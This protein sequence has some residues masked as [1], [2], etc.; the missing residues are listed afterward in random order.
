MQWH[1]RN[2]PIRGS[3]GCILFSNSGMKASPTFLAWLPLLCQ[4]PLPADGE[5]QWRGYTCFL[6]TLAQ[7]S[8]YFFFSTISTYP[9]LK[10]IKGKRN[11]RSKNWKAKDTKQILLV[12]DRI[13]YIGKKKR[14]CRC[15][16]YSFFLHQS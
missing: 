6:M 7:N 2:T 4:N 10:E 12:N 5:K 8:T 16:N 14:I 15:Y 1:N 3:W 13:F 11:Q 9:C